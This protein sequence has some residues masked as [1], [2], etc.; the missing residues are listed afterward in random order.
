M[1]L[2]RLVIAE[3]VRALGVPGVIGVGLTILALVLFATALLP[4]QSRLEG[5]RS[6]EA[7][8]REQQR[9]IE[10][11]IET[12]AQTPQEKLDTF[13]ALFPA[14]ADAAASLEKVYA[15]AESN[16]V[17]LPRGEYA[18]TVDP[19]T[20][21]AQYRVTLPVS[22]SYEQIRGFIAAALRD[23]PTLALDDIE[24]QREKIGDAQLE[25]KVNMT[26]YLAREG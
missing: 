4:A 19:K 23:V 18:L 9:R 15:A 5:S 11:G 8:L 2:S 6:E 24:F 1:R 26:L 7:R 21:L 17:S 22:G 12:R 25:T 13:Y 14:Q 20:G 16:G 10:S 3:T